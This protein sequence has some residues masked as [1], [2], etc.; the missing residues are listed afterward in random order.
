MTTVTAAVAVLS[1][2]LRRVLL[3]RRD[4]EPFR[5]RLGFPG[6]KLEGGESF[7]DAARRE[8]REEAPEIAVDFWGVVGAFH[9][10]DVLM[11]VFGAVCADGATRF[12]SGAFYEIGDL[13]HQ[14]LAPNVHEAAARSLRSIP[15]SMVLPLMRDAT[16][17]VR[18]AGGI[19]RSSLQAVSTRAGAPEMGW[20]HLIQHRRIG[21]VGTALCFIALHRAGTELDRADRESVIST[22]LSRENAAT[23]GWGVRGMAHAGS[24][25]L[26]ESTCYVLDALRV[27]GMGIDEPPV[28]RG[29]DWLLKSRRPDGGWGTTAVLPSRCLPTTL[30]INTLTGW[31]VESG[32]VASA[33]R[34]LLRT[35][36]GD[37]GWGMR[38]HPSEERAD[39]STAPHTARAICALRKAGV[40]RDSREIVRAQQWLIG[41]ASGG[42][43][44]LTEYEVIREEHVDS[45]RLVFGHTAECHPVCA[46]LEAGTPPDAPLVV[47]TVQRMIDEL[48]AHAGAGFANMPGWAEYDRITA[49]SCYC[50]AMLR[51]SPALPD[52]NADVDAALTAVTRFYDARSAAARADTGALPSREQLLRNSARFAA[53]VARAVRT[54]CAVTFVAVVTLLAPGIYA[55]WEA[56]EPI[57]SVL[58][59]LVSGLLVILGARFA[60]QNWLARFDT[61]VE[62]RIRSHLE[63]PPPVPAIGAPRGGAG[64]SLD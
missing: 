55:G 13:R 51:D 19:L 23:G 52:L 31:G 58:S 49:L 5:D 64:V 15:R 30:A 45:D 61:V 24:P 50:D 7:F 47:S 2:D 54:A 11:V 14:E 21:T 17:A 57:L 60:P 6:G 40:P 36:N 48:S 9:A 35:Q 29:I 18:E 27:S 53:G 4:A 26:V 56:Y 34:W 12:D 32:P 22:L 38:P 63:G 62:G 42:W 46:L 39:A 1:P 33:V 28:R 43:K 25:T 3:F 41:C 59:L 16:S 44:E 10:Q 37:G 8:L 20:D